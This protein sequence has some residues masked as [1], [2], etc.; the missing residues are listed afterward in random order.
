MHRTGDDVVDPLEHDA[1]AGE[2]V[3]DPGHL[4]HG[5][6]GRA[7]EPGNGQGVHQPGT[8]VGGH[9]H[10]GQHAVVE[11]REAALDVHRQ[12]VGGEPVGQGVRQRLGGVDERGGEIE[13][14]RCH[15][16]SLP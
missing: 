7:H 13:A 16:M 9:L 4:R 8:V 3:D 1:V 11:A 6:Q 2:V 12:E 10:Q 15:I 5:Q 14:I